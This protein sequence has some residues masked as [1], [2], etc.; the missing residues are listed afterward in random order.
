MVEIYAIRIDEPIEDEIYS[1][2]LSCISEDKHERMEKL[3]F[4]EDAKRMLY[5]DLLARY[6]ACTKLNIHNNRIIFT[7]NEFG[8][9]FLQGYSEF[10]FNISHS[11]DW[12]VCA[13]DNSEVG[14]DIEQV[15]WIDINIAKRF[16]SETEYQNL[17]SQQQELRLEYFYDL[18][19]LKESYIK[20]IGKGLTIPLNSFSICIKKQC[21]ISHEGSL[22]LN[23][24]RIKLDRKYKLSICSKENLL[25]KRVKII[26]INDIKE[27]I[28]H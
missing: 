2:I 27:I 4:K 7:S 19:T 26:R 21:I 10:N 18:W 16:F 11:G 12:V 23:F 20:Y 17:L 13:I 28:L 3:R 15:K 5:G 9:P 14:V 1:Q 24:S 22:I 8:K 25:D 6:L